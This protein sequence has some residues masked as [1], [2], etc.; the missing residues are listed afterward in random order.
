MSSFRNAHPARL[1]CACALAFVLLALVASGAAALADAA[2]ALKPKL[3]PHAVTIQQSHDYLRTH[4]APDYWALSPYYVPQITGSACSLATVA[5][6]VNALRGLPPLSTDELVTQTTLLQAV[7]SDAWASETAANGDGVT[8]DEFKTYLSLSLK[9]FD[10]DADIEV[11]KP[12]DSSPATLAALRAMLADNEQSANDIALVYYNQGVVTGDWDGPHLSPI[13][14]YDG[15]TRRVL[16]MDVD[17]QFYIPYW[18]SDEK[19][20]EALLRPSPANQGRL[21]G[22]TGGIVRVTM[23]P[24]GRA[25]RPPQ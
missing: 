12:S 9:A 13:G 5:T 22:E 8:F 1:A 10:L 19:L 3:G 15:D 14:A 16:I 17:R 11:F 20:L 23:R 21:A 24:G 6:L 25:A 18:V 7:G 4:E 2:D